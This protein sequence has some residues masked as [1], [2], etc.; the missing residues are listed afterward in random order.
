MSVRS[1]SIRRLLSLLVV[2]T[3]VGAG[4]ASILAVQASQSARAAATRLDNSTTARN[5]IDTFSLLDSQAQLLQLAI[6][7]YPAVAST[8]KPALVQTLGQSAAV[9][10][11]LQ[12]ARVSTRVRQSIAAIVSAHEKYQALYTSNYAT[13]TAAEQ[14]AAGAQ[15]TAADTVQIKAVAVTT[16][17]L[18]ADVLAERKA[19][20][21]ATGRLVA[22]LLAVSL[23]GGAV[24]IAVLLL[25]G[26]RLIR[27]I[28]LLSATLSQLS[29]GDLTAS[30]DATGGDEVAH[31]AKRVNELSQRLRDVFSLID[32]T[33][34]RLALSSTS[35]EGVAGRVGASA[36]D[37]SDEAGSVALAA[38][39]V[40]QNVQAVAAGSEQMRASIGEI[41]RNANEAAAV[42]T[43]AV[44]AV[45]ATTATMT[46]LSRSS[47]QIGDVVA[48]I[49]AIA[50]Q[51]NLPR[52][53]RH[54]RGGAGR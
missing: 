27:R 16:A 31:M 30:V 51:T 23:G 43:G 49:A 38:D 28:G 37:T 26:R 8:E 48:L 17:L 19:S 5:T 22:L 15:F 21:Q 33:S 53:Q 50:Q 42:A 10:A 1:W 7:A 54:D 34:D 39:E 35:L 3:V 52:P 40:S 36:S 13:T 46:S 41:A 47:R 25:V 6:T 18:A 11:T 9:I 20:H 32:Q 24:I 12:K 14:Q 45:E 2:V 4:L 29:R 44:S